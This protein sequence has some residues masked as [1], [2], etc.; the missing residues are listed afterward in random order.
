VLNRIATTAA[1]VGALLGALEVGRA[2]TG[3]TFFP[4]LPGA[5]GGVAAAAWRGRPSIP[6]RSIESASPRQTLG[7][8]PTIGDRVQL[9]VTDVVLPQV[10]GRRL[11]HLC[12]ELYPR[13][14]VLYMSGYA[15]GAVVAAGGLEPGLAYIQK[16]LETQ[17]LLEQVRAVLDDPT[18]RPV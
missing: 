3:W 7:L 10:N 6:V 14:R 5:S 2:F 4:Q 15:P 18:P 16:P 13:I 1:S 17:S 8:M 9:L 11:A 12:H